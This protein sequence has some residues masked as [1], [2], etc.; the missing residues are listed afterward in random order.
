MVLE[1]V[2]A[3][4]QNDERLQSSK[5]GMAGELDS[6]RF[7]LRDGRLCPSNEVAMKSFAQ[8]RNKQVGGRFV[9]GLDAVSG[10]VDDGLSQASD[11]GTDGGFG[12]KPR[13][14]DDHGGQDPAADSAQ[15]A[16][17]REQRGDDSAGSSCVAVPGCRRV[18][19]ARSGAVCSKLL[20]KGIEVVSG[21]AWI[22]ARVGTDMPV[23]AAGVSLTAQRAG[24]AVTMTE[25]ARRSI[26]RAVRWRGRR[27]EV[28]S[29]GVRS[30]AACVR[31]R[32]QTDGAS[33][34]GRLHAGTG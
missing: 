24:L 20:D 16:L 33:A 29:A 18:G 6:R 28:G 7:L 3:E 8:V 10:A 31:E 5:F 27:S 12:G 19:A 22:D 13:R 26:A 17:G 25:G 34:V 4:G 23:V 32:G 14:S 21:R 30:D 2:V 11:A 9:P 15:S 1:V